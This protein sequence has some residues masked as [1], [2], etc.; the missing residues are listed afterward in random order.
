M[1]FEIWRRC[2]KSSLRL[3]MELSLGRRF[4]KL[5]A[6]CAGERAPLATSPK[7]P[8]IR[9]VERMA[10]AE[11]SRILKDEVEGGEECQAGTDHVKCI[12]GYFIK[13]TYMR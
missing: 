9:T 10:G 8:T 6:A 1:T 11:I 13:G 5:E 12:L 3:K 2:G 7:R 4:A